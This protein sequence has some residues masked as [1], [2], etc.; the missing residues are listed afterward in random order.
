MRK[1]PKEADAINI[2]SNDLIIKI[3]IVFP[4]GALRA[5][6]SLTQ[7]FYAHSRSD[8]NGYTPFAPVAIRDAPAFEH[9]GVM[10]DISRNWTPPQYVIRTIDIMGFNK[11]N[12]LHLHATDSQSW[13]LKIPSLPTLAREGAYREDQV[14]KAQDLEEVQRYDLYRGV[15]V[16]VEIDTPGHTGSISVLGGSMPKSHRQ[17]N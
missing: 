8:S 14:W 7:L 2:F 5:F 17:A 4:E 11:L 9:R 15:E 6:D 13:P 16:D 12:R 3:R 1:F 10:L